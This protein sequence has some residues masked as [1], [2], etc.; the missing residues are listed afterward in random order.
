MDHR[1]LDTVNDH[2]KCLGQK[3]KTLDC[4]IHRLALLASGSFRGEEVNCEM[5][6]QLVDPLWTRSV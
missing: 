3:K 4:G 6:I 5:N 1:R 2:P